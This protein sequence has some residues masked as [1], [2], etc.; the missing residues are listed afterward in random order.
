M[1]ENNHSTNKESPILACNRAEIL[2]ECVALIVYISRHGDVLPD[3]G[4]PEP[5]G[6]IE[7][8]KSIIEAYKKLV[9]GVMT[10]NSSEATP[11]DWQTLVM[12]Y[13]ELTRF[14]YAQEG[15]NGR[16]VLDTLDGAMRIFDS[17]ETAKP[18]RWWIPSCLS[19]LSCSLK[20]QHCPLLY[21]GLFLFTA[22]TLEL[23]TGWT[24]RV[25]DP[26]K[27]EGYLKYQYDFI[28]DLAPLLVPAVWGAIGACVYLMKRISDKL[29]KLAYEQSRQQ[30]NG[31]RILLGA[32]LGVVVV[33]LMFPTH[34]ETLA[35]GEVNLGPMV[36]AFAVGLSVKPIYAAF[37]TLVEGLAE[38]FSPK[39]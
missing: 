11:M 24:G 4:K 23:F 10:C 33:E 22:L 27:L 30:G 28:I 21:A 7:E 19:R 38:R 14:T 34:S 37:E 9:T 1:T 29:G 25:S 39:K 2:K 3:D 32:V 18:L 5:A 15:V 31:A 20:R 26:S 17:G 6:S 16:S 8:D 13:T 36:A 35:V 12:A